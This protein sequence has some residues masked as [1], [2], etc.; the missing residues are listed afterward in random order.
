MIFRGSFWH[1]GGILRPG[2]RVFF[3]ASLS[4]TV[5]CFVILHNISLYMYGVQTRK[6]TTGKSYSFTILIYTVHL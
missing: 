6:N 5:W 4:F 1:L 3:P 2:P